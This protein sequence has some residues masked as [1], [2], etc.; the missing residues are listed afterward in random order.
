MLPDVCPRCDYSWKGLPDEGKCPECGLSYDSNTRAWQLHSCFA[1]TLLIGL[2]ATVAIPLGYSLL[3][4][5]GVLYGHLHL[6][7]TI[8]LMGLAAGYTVILA[9]L[10]ARQR[11]R[12][13]ISVGPDGILTCSQDH[14]RLIP[15]S[16][17]NGIEDKWTSIYIQLLGG[18]SIRI[19]GDLSGPDFETL[20]FAVRSRLGRE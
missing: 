3:L 1:R 17:V 2:S 7:P 10:L 13:K 8:M 4:K 9:R 16:T 11:G 19:E 14:A 12:H 5:S 15:W 20:R 6:L 18:K